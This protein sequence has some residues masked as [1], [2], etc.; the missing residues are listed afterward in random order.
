MNKKFSLVSRFTVL[1]LADFT[2]RALYY[3]SYDIRTILQ[4]VF[5]YN[6]SVSAILIA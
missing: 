4:A 5:F 1:S 2:I 3:C 6:Q